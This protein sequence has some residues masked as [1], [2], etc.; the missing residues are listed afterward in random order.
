MKLLTAFFIAISPPGKP[1]SRKFSRVIL[2]DTNNY[3]SETIMFS[4]K[5]MAKIKLSDIPAY[6]IAQQAGLNP[7]TLS[8][9]MRGIIPLKPNDERVIAVGRVL[10]IP[11]SECF[12]NGGAGNE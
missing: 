8:Q 12:D 5:L 10:G 2:Y 3:F 9:L 6:K 4:E 11:E 1:E 7:C